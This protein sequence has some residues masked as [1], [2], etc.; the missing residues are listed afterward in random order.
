MS[1]LVSR[2]DTSLND[3]P[4]KSIAISTFIS[5]QPIATDTRPPLIFA[6]GASGSM[7]TPAVLSFALGAAS[8]A[9]V[10]TFQGT[11]NMKARVSAFIAVT[12]HAASQLI[13][14]PG[15][16]FND[17]DSG[18]VLGGRSMGSRAAILAANELAPKIE[19]PENIAVPIA[20][21]LVLVSYPLVAPSGEVRDQL[22]LDLGEGYEVLFIIGSR[23]A[24]CPLDHLEDVRRKMKAKSWLLQVH[25]ADHGMSVTPKSVV[26]QV[27]EETGRIAGLWIRDRDHARRE[28]LIEV[29]TDHNEAVVRWGG[30]CKPAPG[31]AGGDVQAS[32]DNV[33]QRTPQG[34][35]ELKGKQESEK[36][37]QKN[38]EGEKNNGKSSRKR[39]QPTVQEAPK[40]HVSKRAKSDE[41]A[42][43]SEASDGIASRT[44]SRR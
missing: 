25:G 31:C 22:L 11:M 14:Q 36:Q 38:N 18:I 3:T 21:R 5:K 7:H 19:L 15:E 16:P 1:A 43:R 26:D 13:K 23:D 35:K 20:K 39:K 6:H 29:E 9:L 2:Q 33:R 4:G 28:S 41:T 8:S 27:V 42:K 30:W 34:K 37:K 10:I 40:R 32:K 17:A 24:M 44:R 12:R